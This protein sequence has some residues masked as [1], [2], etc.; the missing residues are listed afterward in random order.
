MHLDPDPSVW[1]HSHIRK[2]HSRNLCACWCRCSC[3]CVHLQHFHST[4]SKNSKLECLLEARQENIQGKK[5]KKK[6]K[7]QSIRESSHVSPP[8]QPAPW[9]AHPSTAALPANAFKSLSVSLKRVWK[10]WHVVRRHGLSYRGCFVKDLLR[11]R[12]GNDRQWENWW[13]DSGIFLEL[14]SNLYMSPCHH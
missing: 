13:G 6:K 7:N 11:G 2:Q 4:S 8:L 5:K 3:V 14:P 9:L 1:A 10:P 12:R